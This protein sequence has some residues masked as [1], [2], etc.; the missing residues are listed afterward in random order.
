MDAYLRRVPSF[1]PNFALYREADRPE[2]SPSALR[3]TLGDAMYFLLTIPLAE[4]L[5]Y[6]H[7]TDVIPAVLPLY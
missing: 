4:G 7:A 2:F 5:D 1:W 6:L 3:R